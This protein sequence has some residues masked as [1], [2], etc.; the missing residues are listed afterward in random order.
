MNEWVIIKIPLQGKFFIHFSLSLFLI[1][2]EIGL[3]FEFPFPLERDDET[4]GHNKI[5]WDSTCTHASWL[6]YKA[7]GYLIVFF[8]PPRRFMHF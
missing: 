3:P 7:Q 2:S 8:F 4:A 6:L 1:H 5:G